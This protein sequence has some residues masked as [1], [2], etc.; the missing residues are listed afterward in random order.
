VHP[1]VAAIWRSSAIETCMGMKHD[2]WKLIA[3]PVAAAKSSSTSR[4]QEVAEGSTLQIISVSSAYWRTG[5]G[6]ADERG[7]RSLPWEKACRIRR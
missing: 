4:R 7:C 5:Q 6:V 1:R 3:S 2:L